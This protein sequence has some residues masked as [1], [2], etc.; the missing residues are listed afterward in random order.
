MRDRLDIVLTV[1]VTLVVMTMVGVF[2]VSCEH[3]RDARLERMKAGHSTT[4]CQEGF[5]F[6][7]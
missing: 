4:E 3:A 6:N 5:G 1:C 2:F 7:K